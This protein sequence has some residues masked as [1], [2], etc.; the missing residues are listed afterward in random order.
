VSA[1]VQLDYARKVG[2]DLPAILLRCPACG[3][4]MGGYALKVDWDSHGIQCSR[5]EL[6]I[7]Q[8]DGVWKAMR[9]GRVAEIQPFLDAYERVRRMEGRWSDDRRYY[10]SLPWRDTSRRFAGQWK[11]RSKSFAYLQDHILPEQ[12]RRSKRRQLRVLDIGAGN[13]WM[14]YRLALAGHAPVAVDISVNPWD[15]LR[16]A[17]H[18]AS[19]LDAIFPRFQ[20]EMD[21]LP[22]DSGQFDLAIFNASFHYSRD[23]T[24]TIREATRVLDADGA[25]VIIDSPTYSRE[26]GGRAMTDEKSA[27]FLR[28]F[29]ITDGTMGGQQYLTPRRLKDLEPLGI[30]WQRYSPWYGWRWALRPAVALATG[31]RAPSR[32]HIYLGRKCSGR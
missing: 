18:Y 29:G 16:A 13:C 7:E 27:E 3:N 11:I 12:I 4:P 26:C 6:E 22:F 23:Y 32:F 2:Y 8:V 31:R 20:A 28:R 1:L 9:P 30:R 15:G 25:V 5:C 19:A 24:R 17:M 10:L 14:S 21:C